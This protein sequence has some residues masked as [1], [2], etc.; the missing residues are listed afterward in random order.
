MNPA[1]LALEG[2]ATGRRSTKL[3]PTILPSKERKQKIDREHNQYDG[4]RI[5]QATIGA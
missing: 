4:T 1:L 5:V 3:A 2:L